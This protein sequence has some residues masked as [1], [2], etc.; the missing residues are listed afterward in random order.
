MWLPFKI[1]PWQRVWRM[2]DSSADLCR[3]SRFLFSR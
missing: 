2:A 1:R 3:L